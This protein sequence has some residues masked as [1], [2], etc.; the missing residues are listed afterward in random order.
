[1][2]K[3]EKH[4]EHQWEDKSSKWQTVYQC[5]LCGV[6]SFEQPVQ[7]EPVQTTPNSEQLKQILDGLDRCIHRD[8]KQE[9]LS[10]WIRDWTEHKL[11]K[12]TLSTRHQ[13]E[14]K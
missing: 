14:T 13:G 2:S 7:H 4:C 6:Y 12:H 1:M 3:D 8:S 11:A 9:F 10:T 5:E